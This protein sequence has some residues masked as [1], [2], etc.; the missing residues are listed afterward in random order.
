MADAQS[1][2]K[3]LGLRVS[4]IGPGGRYPCA[5]M[6]AD[7][8][9]RYWATITAGQYWFGVQPKPKGVLSPGARAAFEEA[10]FN[11]SPNGK[12]AYVK[13][14][15]DLDDAVSKARAAMARIRDVLNELA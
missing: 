9:Y 13:L 3:S 8:P 1:L 6:A 4:S 12:E 11:I 10:A 2:M 14:G 5:D 15:D 7:D